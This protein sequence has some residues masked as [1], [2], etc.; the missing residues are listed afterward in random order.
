MF[1]L[2]RIQ[3]NPWQGKSEEGQHIEECL[4]RRTTPG[5]GAHN[6]ADLTFGRFGGCH[7]VIRGWV[8]HGG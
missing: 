8:V 3:T 1:P 6:A 7:W 5:P 4:S 2:H